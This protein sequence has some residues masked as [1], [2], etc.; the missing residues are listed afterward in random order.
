MKDSFRLKGYIYQIDETQ[1]V[2]PKFQ[3]R[4]FVIMMEKKVKSKGKDYEFTE[5]IKFQLIQD[6]CSHLD[7]YAINEYVEV[8]FF[9]KGRKYE[10]KDTEETFYFNSLD[11]Y[12]I[13]P[14][15]VPKKKVKNIEEFDQQ[16][17]PIEDNG[18]ALAPNLTPEQPTDDLPF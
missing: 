13:T 18:L 2:T 8:E 1:Q 11:V 16:E 3:K 12:N 4:D 14:L 15:N 6:K 10:K 5:Y 9:V 17:L 7:V